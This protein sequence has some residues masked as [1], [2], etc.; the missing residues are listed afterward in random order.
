MVQLLD[1]GSIL[2]LSVAS[3]SECSGIE[4]TLEVEEYQEGGVN[5]RVHKFP[6]RFTFAN[7]ILKRG[8]SLD[9]QLRMWHRALLD[10]KPDRRDGLII[11][12]NEFK[13]P[14]AAWKFDRGLAVKY[15]GP[16]LNAT[17]NGSSIETLEIA[18]E[19]LENFDLGTLL[20]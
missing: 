11:V 8:V 3:F 2:P 15:T 9:P 5:D 12:Q 18:H 10:G 17:Q 1:S 7:I 6:S 13:L 16:D 14:V 19:R 4:S 20:F